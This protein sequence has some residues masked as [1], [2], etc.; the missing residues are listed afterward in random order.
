MHGEKGYIQFE[1]EWEPVPPPAGLHVDELI[2]WRD[3]IH[4]KGLIGVYPD[5]IG[6]G[7]ISCRTV[8][9][10][11]FFITGTATGGLPNLRPEHITEVV[12]FNFAANR[13]R[14]RGPVKASSEALS[15]AAVYRSVPTT[16][17][18]VHVHHPGMWEYLCN[19]IPTTDANAEAGTPQMAWAIESLFAHNVPDGLFVMGGHREGLVTWGGTLNEAGD[20]MMRALDEFDRS[21]R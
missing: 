15:H 7:N 17:A 1:C 18:V 5:G 19:R 3:L 21:R 10:A 13:V 6:Y 4:R 11:T 2:R 12:D 16:A 14:C 20:R 8:G 9:E